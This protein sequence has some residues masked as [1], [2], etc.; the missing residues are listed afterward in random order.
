ML[1]QFS[2][3][4]PR[5]ILSLLGG[6]LL[7][8]AGFMMGTAFDSQA[9]QAAESALYDSYN[10]QVI[11]IS[12]AASP[13]DPVWVYEEPDPDSAQVDRLLW[14]DRVLWRGTE[15]QD[16]N[17]NRWIYVG[18]SE[19]VSG[20]MQANLTDVSSG[21]LLISDATYTTP[22][23]ELGATVTV[24]PDG[25][26]ANFRAAPSVSAENQRKVQAGETLTVVGGP[27][28][29]ELFIWWQYEDAEGNTGWI[30]DIQGWLTVQ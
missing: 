28:Q 19:G 1:S 27:Y 12:S 22:G 25:A 15:Q 2:L 14:G 26:A 11:E 30:V 21:R 8:V 18:L 17:D 20:W 4:R 9:P 7:L 3:G 5:L 10:N 24:S 6:A 29:N 16:A 23:I 13:D